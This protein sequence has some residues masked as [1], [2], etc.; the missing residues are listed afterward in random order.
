MGLPGLV[1]KNIRCPIKFEFQKDIQ[2][3]FSVSVSHA[4]SVIYLGSEL[5]LATLD[6]RKRKVVPFYSYIQVAKALGNEGKS[7]CMTQT[8]A[9]F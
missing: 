3:F 1:D 2:Y 5:C 6:L 9:F 8:T 7:G 4:V